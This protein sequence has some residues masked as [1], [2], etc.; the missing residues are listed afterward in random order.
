[1]PSIVSTQSRL[2]VLNTKRYGDIG[3]LLVHGDGVK[4]WKIKHSL[5]L[6]LFGCFFLASVVVVAAAAVAAV[7]G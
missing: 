7:V 2:P 1:M 6:V 3:E 4:R 5:C